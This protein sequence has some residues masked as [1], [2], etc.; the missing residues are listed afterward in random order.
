L[1]EI[2][3]QSVGEDLV[4]GVGGKKHKNKFPSYKLE[5]NKVLTGFEVYGNEKLE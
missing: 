2:S 5:E 4:S 1:G 3:W